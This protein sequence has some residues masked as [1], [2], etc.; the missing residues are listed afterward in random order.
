MFSEIQL[1]ELLELKFLSLCIQSKVAS[2]PEKLVNT[3]GTVVIHRKVWSSGPYL[4]VIVSE[5]NQENKMYL[6]DSGVNM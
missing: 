1:K 5:I 3:Q 4:L 2:L 6:E